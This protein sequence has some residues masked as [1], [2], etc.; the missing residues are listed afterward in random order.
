MSPRGAGLSWARLAVSGDSPAGAPGGEWC[1]ERAWPAAC[2]EGGQVA[3]SMRA[4]RASGCGSS[5][6]RHSGRRRATN[7]AHPPRELPRNTTS[8]GQWCHG[9]GIS[10]G[11]RVGEEFMGRSGRGG[12]QRT[13]V[14]R[15]QQLVSAG[16][17]LL[18]GL[19]TRTV[20]AREFERATGTLEHASVRAQV[21][22]RSGSP[23]HAPPSALRSP[24]W[25]PASG[26]ATLPRNWRRAGAGAHD[27][28]GQVRSF[29]DSPDQARSVAPKRF[30]TA[31]TTSAWRASTSASVSVRSGAR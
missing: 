17:S 7:V 15:D 25:S 2:L 26:A 1:G 3:G 12:S 30:W 13:R 21:L 4:R 14:L 27:S 31:A 8:S 24:W 28:T 20:E 5:G 10:E 22:A 9:C 16:F 11:P 19:P 29:T 18:D 6:V 23:S